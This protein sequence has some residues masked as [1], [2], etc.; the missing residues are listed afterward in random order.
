[1][2]LCVI[3]YEKLCLSYIFLFNSRP[4]YLELSYSFIP[5]YF[6]IPCHEVAEQ[7]IV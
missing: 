1:M 5:L 4:I 3:R 7:I 6:Y 2:V